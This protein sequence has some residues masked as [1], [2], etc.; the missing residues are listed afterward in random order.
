MYIRRRTSILAFLKQWMFKGIVF[1]VYDRVTATDQHD[2]LVIIQLPCFI[3][4]EQFT[5]QDIKIVGTASVFTLCFAAALFVYGSLT[6]TFADIFM[7]GLFISAQI[8][9]RIAVTRY[10]LPGVLKQ[11]FDLR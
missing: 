11:S 3:R 10:G 8:N 7:C 4:S 9:K 2:T 1:P 6:K 5:P